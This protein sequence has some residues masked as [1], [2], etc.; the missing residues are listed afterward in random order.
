MSQKKPKKN[1]TVSDLD[2]LIASREGKKSQTSIGNIR[3]VRKIIFE[4]I[5]TDKRVFNLINKIMWK[6]WE[7]D[8]IKRKFPKVSKR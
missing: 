5:D 1:F 7:K 2:S 6:S 3:E 4:L 8:F